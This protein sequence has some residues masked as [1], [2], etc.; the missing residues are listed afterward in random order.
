TGFRP[1]AEPVQSEHLTFNLTALRPRLAAGGS[2]LHEKQDLLA[3]S[4]QI[5]HNCAVRLLAKQLTIS[6]IAAGLFA[7]TPGF[8]PNVLAFPESLPPLEAALAAFRQTRYRD[9]LDHFRQALAEAQRAGG[10][11]ELKGRILRGTGACFAVLSDYQAAL[12]Q[13][14]LARSYTI[15]GG[16]SEDLA[17][18][19][20]NIGSV[21]LDQGEWGNAER[22]YRQALGWL[23]ASPRSPLRAVILLNL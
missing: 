7:F 16:N 5:L 23:E 20:T 22:L 15:Q 13:F 21:Y 19:D 9:A 1:L 17:T 2:R 4:R 12:E 3:T 11:A 6:V 14:L 8:V 10:S 18:I